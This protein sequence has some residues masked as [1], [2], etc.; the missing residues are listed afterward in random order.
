[1]P[2]PPLVNSTPARGA[3]HQGAL[4]ASRGAPRSPPS[5]IAVDASG[6]TSPTRATKPDVCTS[7]ERECSGEIS[8]G[9][10][11]RM[12]R[13]LLLC[14]LVCAVAAAPADAIVGG[15]DA[16]P[17]EYPAVADITFGA[18]GCTGTLIA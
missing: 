11:P 1:M 7:T 10:E 8:S 13:I 17:G 14:S 3:V 9:G 12:R 4:L 5:M 6:G 16:S 15:Q 18:F 2:N